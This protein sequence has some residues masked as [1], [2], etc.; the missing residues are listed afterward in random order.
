M[1]A[2]LRS[3]VLSIMIAQGLLADLKDYTIASWNLSGG[4]PSE[5]KWQHI[6]RGL[7]MGSNG[8]DIVVLQQVESLAATAR[9]LNTFF[10]P[11]T[12]GVLPVEEYQW[13]LGGNAFVF[14]YFVRVDSASNGVNLA[15]V[16]KKRAHHIVAIRSPIRFAPPIFGIQIDQDVF[17]S[18]SSI[19]AK[20]KDVPQTLSTIYDNFT[21][22]PEVSWALIGNFNQTP[23]TL[24]QRLS[25]QIQEH[26]NI[27]APDT[28]TRKSGGVFDFIITGNSGVTPYYAP[29]LVSGL[30]SVGLQFDSV[31]LPVWFGK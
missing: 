5:Y 21:L 14:V 7:L 15:I 11:I 26:I 28:I 4:M 31:Y 22:R 27:V 2:I 13:D 19:D 18:F 1:K 24:Q 6:V 10:V 16:T 30:V 17:L 9:F 23:A 20:G 3:F 29:A 25:P 12:S 8:A